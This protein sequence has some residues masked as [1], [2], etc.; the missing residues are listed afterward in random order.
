VI[1]NEMSEPELSGTWVTVYREITPRE[2]LLI[3]DDYWDLARR[4]ADIASSLQPVLDRLD[5]TWTGKAKSGFFNEYESEAVS[6][7]ILSR[8]VEDAMRRI[9]NIKVVQ[10]EKVFKPYM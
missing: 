6:I 10:E 7:N 1:L 9:K 8:Q 5:R 2:A 4:I 3:A